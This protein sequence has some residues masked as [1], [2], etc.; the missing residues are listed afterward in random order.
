[1]RIMVKLVDVNTGSPPNKMRVQFTVFV[2]ALVAG[3]LDHG[4]CQ[5]DCAFPEESDF[6]S[7][8]ADSLLDG[9][10]TLRPT[11]T[12]SRSQIVCLAHSEER[13]RYRFYSVLVNYTCPRGSNTNCP[14]DGVYL[15]EQFEAQCRSES[16]SGIVLG[17]FDDTRD[18]SPEATFDTS[19]REDCSFC[20]SEEKRPNTPLPL[21]LVL[22]PVTHCVG[23]CVFII[24]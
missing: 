23:E 24:A 6:E 2:V 20:V 12:I 14:D 8:I 3:F 19:L 16:W 11:I 4:Y 21:E 7:V 15:V 9:S 5:L 17:S 1:M 10:N 18:E 13:G 22:D